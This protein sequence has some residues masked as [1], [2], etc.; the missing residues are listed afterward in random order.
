MVLGYRLD[1]NFDNDNNNDFISIALFRVNEYKCE[2]AKHMHYEH[3]IP[4]QHLCA[5]NL[6]QKPQNV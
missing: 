5:Y 2:N 1:D 3:H 6:A 4:G